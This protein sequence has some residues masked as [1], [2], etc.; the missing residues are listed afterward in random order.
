MCMIDLL[1]SDGVRR[2]QLHTRQVDKEEIQTST[3]TLTAKS[4]VVV[5]AAGQGYTS[6]VHR[7]AIGET[8]STVD[9]ATSLHASSFCLCICVHVPFVPGNQFR[10]I[11]LVLFNYVNA[12]SRSIASHVYEEAKEEG[13]LTPSGV[14]SGVIRGCHT[15]RQST[16]AIG[17]PRKNHITVGRSEIAKITRRIIPLQQFIEDQISGLNFTCIEPFY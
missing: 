17:K 10:C 8:L 11:D 3:A 9:I 14:Q 7:P 12:N 15:K 1:D 4:W 16:L 2:T 6:L 5:V 13:G